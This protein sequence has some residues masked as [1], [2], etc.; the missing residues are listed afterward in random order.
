MA[1]VANCPQCEH[2]MLIPDG[3]GDDAW[4]KCPECRAFFQL[5]QAP[6]RELASALLV[7]ADESA[8]ADDEIPGLE[9]LSTEASWKESDDDQVVAAPSDEMGLADEIGLE[10]D[11]LKL[12]DEQ[13]PTTPSGDQLEA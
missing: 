12:D 3:V 10:D 8:S 4:A 5:N 13:E 7:E 6:T 1:R 9:D 11:D 2:E